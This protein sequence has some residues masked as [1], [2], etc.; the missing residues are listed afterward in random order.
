MHPRLTELLADAEAVRADLL[1]F[2][3]TLGDDD[4]TSAPADG[5]WSVAQHA[6]HL[7][8]V[9]QSSVRALFRAFRTA[10]DAGLGP[11]TETSSRLG[12]LAHTGLA[13]GN[14]RVQAPPFV[15]PVDVPDRAQVHARLG[16]SR[17]GLHAWAAEADGYRLTEVSFPHPV[18]GALDLY[19]WVTMIADHERR[20]LGQLRRRFAAPAA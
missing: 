12:A 13:E 6:A 15:T 9:E 3:D 4:W 8:L 20:H 16:E 1:A 11:E 7:H 2:L 19:A 14:V 17:A 18:L 10:R 5:G